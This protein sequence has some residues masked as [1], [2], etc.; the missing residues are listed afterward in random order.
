MAH[1]MSPA[2]NTV[3]ASRIKSVLTSRL[4]YPLECVP[5]IRIVQDPWIWFYKSVR[6]VRRACENRG[7]RDPQE[8]GAQ[9]GR[10]SPGSWL[11]RMD[12]G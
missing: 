12:K 7:R 9:R 3:S 6:A 2:K 1:G 11:D 10:T 8:T 4:L 5:A